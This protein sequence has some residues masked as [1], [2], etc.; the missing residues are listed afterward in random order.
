[1]N[2]KANKLIAFAIVGLFVLTGTYNAVVINSKSHISGS[3]VK[4]VKRLDEIYGVT[5]SGRKLASSVTWKKVDPFAVFVEQKSIVS[6]ISPSAPKA[7][8][9][10]PESPREVAAVQEELSLNLVEVVNPNKWHNGLVATSFSGSLAT[11]NGVIE[12]LSVS[13]PND[14]GISVSFLEMTGN[15]FEYD[16]NGELCSGMMYQVDK[17]TYVV[18]LT[19]GPLEGTRLRFSSQASEAQQI[20]SEQVLAGS[21]IEVGSFGAET[22]N[23]ESLAQ[24][25]QRMQQEAF[26][27]QGFN[28]GSSVEL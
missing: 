17:N 10:A 3:E 24:N 2:I 7:S 18:T 26:Q 27:A 12:N 4:F 16:F 22:V 19:N 13:L 14:E 23:T 28:I 5:V 25:D 21:S 15:V 1:M 20:Q 9:E 8:E 11:N 6:F